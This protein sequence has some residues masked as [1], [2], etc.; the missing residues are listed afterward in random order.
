M[1]CGGK[2]G[3]RVRATLEKRL[4]GNKINP[5]VC[6]VV[7]KKTVRGKDVRTAYP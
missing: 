3:R 5:D 6:F 1:R 2:T 4:L 7:I